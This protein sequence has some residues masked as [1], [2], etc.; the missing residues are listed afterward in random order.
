MSR[1]LKRKQQFE[2]AVSGGNTFMLDLERAEVLLNTIVLPDFRSD[3]ALRE[4]VGS[5]YGASGGEP[6]VLEILIEAWSHWE[7]LFEA[8]LR[9]VWE[10]FEAYPPQF[11]AVETLRQLCTREH[12]VPETMAEVIFDDP[13]RDVIAYLNWHIDSEVD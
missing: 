1:I 13:R 7:D 12:G 3:E 4:L 8:N 10:S 2:T 11:D 6:A 5:V 9:L